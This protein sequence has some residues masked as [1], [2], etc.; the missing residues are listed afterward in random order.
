MVSFNYRYNYN[1]L[2]PDVNIIDKDLTNIDLLE[3][4]YPSSKNLLCSFHVLK[5]F[6]TLVNSRILDVRAPVKEEI[7]DLLIGMVHAKNDDVVHSLYNDIKDIPG[8][9]TFHLYIILIYKINSF[10]YKIN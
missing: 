7:Q 6:K 5:W 9:V 3:K 4:F 1:L 10:L 8:L 2:I